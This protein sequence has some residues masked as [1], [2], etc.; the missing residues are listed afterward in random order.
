MISFK[1]VANILKEREAFVLVLIDGDGMIF[2][3]ELVKNGESG[4]KEAAAMLW[5]AVKAYVQIELPHI[6]LDY[7]IMTRIYANLKGLGDA[8][9][10]IGIIHHP[11][12]IEEFARGLT[13]SKLLFDFVDVGVGKDRADDKINGKPAEYIGE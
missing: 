10:K 6:P 7:K 12:I 2:N 4:G 11:S 8:C 9:H 3:D 1:V 5:D 13:G